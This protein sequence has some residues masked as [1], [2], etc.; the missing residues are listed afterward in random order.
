MYHSFL[1]VRAADKLTQN[2]LNNIL[3]VLSVINFI[4]NKQ[5]VWIQSSILHL[6]WM[7]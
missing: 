2:L 7:G 3:C 4:R 6:E 5:L 1:S